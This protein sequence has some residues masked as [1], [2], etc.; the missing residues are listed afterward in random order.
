MDK[1]AK[2]IKYGFERRNPDH[3]GVNNAGHNA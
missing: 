1:P 2:K 3:R